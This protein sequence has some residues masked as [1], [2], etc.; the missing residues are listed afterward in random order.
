MTN[1]SKSPP[2]PFAFAKKSCKPT[3]APAA[4][5]KSAPAKK[6]EADCSEEARQPGH[7]PRA[8]PDENSLSGRGCVGPR[9]PAAREFPA[10]TRANGRTDPGRRP[11]QRRAVQRGVDRQA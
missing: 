11:A 1:S 2:N 4:G 8:K 5:K 3:A 7:Q 9:V 10:E 6:P